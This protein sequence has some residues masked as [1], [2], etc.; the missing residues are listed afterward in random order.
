MTGRVFVVIL[1]WNGWRDTVECLESVWRSRGVGFDVVVCDN[2]STD[3]SVAHIVDWAAGRERVAP[4]AVPPELACHVSPPCAKPIACRVTDEAGA[5]APAPG[6]EAPSAAAPSLTVIRNRANLGFA[7]G[8]NVGLRFALK[9]AQCEAVWLLNNDTVVA[10]DAL[11]TLLAKVAADARI[12]ICGSTVLYYRAPRT[13]QAQGGAALDRW[14]GV[15]RHL[16]D[17][18]PFSPDAGAAPAEG[19]MDY[20]LGASMLVTRA[21]L[22]AIGLM[23]EDYFLY[24]EELD[25]AMRARG[26][27][28]LGYAPA[29][30]VWHKEGAS[31]G[32]SGAPERRSAM[33][34]YYG[35]RSRLVFMRRFFPWRMP[36]VY[37]GM[38]VS[39]LK[40]IGRGQPERASELLR[41]MLSPAS[42]PPS[43]TPAHASTEQRL[44]VDG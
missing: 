5:A 22:E 3:G 26:R 28:T 15:T 17:G 12:G 31:I 35:A 29:S 19:A 34:D 2:A 23:A 40:R 11:G 39:M 21:F 24:Y 37:A 30:L 32:S 7:G 42:R 14:F 4:D 36:A 27:F 33:S 25:W 18:Q 8:M 20:V 13:I 9:H 44:D 38:V 6:A 10:A 1:N 43:A 16:G 41:I